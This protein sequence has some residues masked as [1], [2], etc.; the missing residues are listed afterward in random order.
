LRGTAHQ[1]VEPDR[2]SWIL[3]HMH[4]LR[5]RDLVCYCDPEPCH[6]HVYAKIL[7]ELYGDES[8]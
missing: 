3:T 1:E 4:M 5:G 6:G 8:L 2:R 7:T